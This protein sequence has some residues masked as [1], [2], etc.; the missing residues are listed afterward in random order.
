MRSKNVNFL[1]FAFDRVEINLPD[2]TIEIKLSTI[3]PGLSILYTFL[4]TSLH[5]RILI[6][7]KLCG[8]EENSKRYDDSDT[9]E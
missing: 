3:L 6:L 9:A 8:F 5:E 1:D 2:R 4:M 7:A